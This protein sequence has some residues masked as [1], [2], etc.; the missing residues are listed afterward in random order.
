M[1]GHL[2]RHFVCRRH[3][4]SCA[5]WV[6]AG[7][8]HY[9]SGA[10]FVADR[11]GASQT[12]GS[13][14]LQHAMCIANTRNQQTGQD[15]CRRSLTQTPDIDRPVPDSHGCRRKSFHANN[16]QRRC[17]PST[18]ERAQRTDPQFR[19]AQRC[20]LVVSREELNS[21]RHHARRTSLSRVC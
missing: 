7:R 1:L 15:A 6:R 5:G 10:C 13:M 4:Q 17:R 3:I 2:A 8:Q 9:N 12:R 16:L 21:P 20:R 19:H 11:D 14:L 18:M